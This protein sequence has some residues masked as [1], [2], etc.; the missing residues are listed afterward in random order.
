MI[1][2]YGQVCT[3][4]KYELYKYYRLDK[5]RFKSDFILIFIAPLN[6]HFSYFFKAA[7][8]G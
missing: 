3:E 1:I 6:T 7:Y 8:K 5:G 4:N 2:K